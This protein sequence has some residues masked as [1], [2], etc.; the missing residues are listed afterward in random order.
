MM[1]IID[2]AKLITVESRLTE[3]PQQQACRTCD[4]TDNS[5]CPDRISVDFIISKH[6]Q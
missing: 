4:I 1:L 5:Q 2:I 6:P 3:T